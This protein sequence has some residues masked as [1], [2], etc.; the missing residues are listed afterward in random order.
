MTRS[1]L[2]AT[3]FSK[4]AD[5]GVRWATEV[6]QS[7]GAT[8]HVLHSFKLP[9]VG[10]PYSPP[11]AKMVEALEDRVH[12]LLAET[13]EKVKAA[14]VAVEVEFARGR[15]FDAIEAAARSLPAD[16]IVLGTQ[17]QG[18][19]EHLL[20]GSTAERVVSRAPCPVLAVHPGD[21]A[22]ERPTS[23][24]VPCDFSEEAFAAAETAM[25]LFSSSGGTLH[26]MHAYFLP[27]EYGAYGAV[28]AS[29]EYLA[30]VAQSSLKELQEW[31]K[32]L[33]GRGWDVEC[34][35]TEGP[36]VTAVLR[37]SKEKDIDLIAMGTH[38]RSKVAEL[39]LGSVAKKVLQNATCPVLT[40]P[41]RS[42]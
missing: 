23:I 19:V 24:L 7:S 30:E 41:R 11:P 29:Q 4:T 9:N 26:V 5:A 20:L 10:T 34:E 13:A 8:V 25:A 2:V 15:P 31:A 3:D 17:G 12:A 37:T 28:A 21:G 6:A 40:V 16:L 42:L 39:V 36:A 32:P 22:S 14:G 1:I 18:F 27:I 38:G 33:S 35:V